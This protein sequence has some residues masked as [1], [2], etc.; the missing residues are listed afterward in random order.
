MTDRRISMGLFNK[1]RSLMLQALEE[2]ARCADVPEADLW[3]DA[4]ATYSAMRQIIELAK[5]KKSETP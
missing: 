5:E 4:D 3:A 2:I 1:Y